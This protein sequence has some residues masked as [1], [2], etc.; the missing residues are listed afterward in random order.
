MANW[1]NRIVSH[2][3]R[4]AKE[5]LANPFNYKIHTSLQDRA[6]EGSLDS[7]GWI[8]EVI[9]NRRTGRVIDGHERITLALRKGE[10]TPV[11]YKEVD[12]SEAEELQALATLDPMIA[13]AQTDSGKLDEL[14]RQINSDDERIQEFLANL[15]A[16][17]GIVGEPPSLDDLEDQFGDP[18][19]SDFWPVISVKVHPD[20]HK[21]FMDLMGKAPVEAEGE[22]MALILKSVD[23]SGW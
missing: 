22:K 3:E 21:L 23:V 11:P 2:G 10:D 8:D 4:P 9:V 1:Q 5:F 16:K 15:A 14:L 18:D 20:V 7:L 12:L 13:L 19:E 6:L 17:E